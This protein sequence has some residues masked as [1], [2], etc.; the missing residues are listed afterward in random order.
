VT[1]TAQAALVTVG[2]WAIVPTLLSDILRRHSK[3]NH[4][5]ILYLL[6]DLYSLVIA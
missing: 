1:V 4:S 3:D 6:I 5:Q 2:Q